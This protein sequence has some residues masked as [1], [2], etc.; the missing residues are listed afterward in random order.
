VIHWPHLAPIA[1]AALVGITLI[2][3]SIAASR[4]RSV[5]HALRALAARWKMTYAQ[6]DRLRIGTRIR[7]SLP[8]P[9]AARV[10]VRDIIYG[11]AADRHRAVFT[12]EFTVGVIHSQKRLRRVA[13]LIEPRDPKQSACDVCF[14]PED[15]PLIEQYR[16][17]HP[18]IDSKQDSASN[19]AESGV[20]T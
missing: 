11:A 16:F 12:V 17:L 8:V 15:L 3:A 1:L 5:R 7:G 10:Q 18:R 20:P 19:D 4:R 2:A 9:G 6:Q 14:A 13:S